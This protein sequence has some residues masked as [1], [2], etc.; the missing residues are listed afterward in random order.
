MNPKVSVIL[1]TYNRASYLYSAIKSVLNQ[2][3]KDFE[4][5]IV[6]DAS[7]DNTKQIIDKF[8]DRRIYYIRHKENKGGS[9]ARNTGIKR[10]KGEFIAFLD[11]DDLWMPN[12]LEKQLNFI[13]NNHE[14]SVVYTGA[15]VINKH[16]KITDIIT[17]SLRGNIFPKLLKKN[18]IGSCSTVLIKKECINRVGLFDE[19]LSASQ[20]FDLWIRLAK[21]YYFD[22]INEPLFFYRVHEKRIT[23]NPQKRLRAKKLLYTKH[24]EELDRLV[25]NT[26]ARKILGFWHYVLGVLYCQCGEIG[27]GKKELIMAIRNDPSSIPYYARLLFAFSGSTIFDLTT[28]I[29]NSYIPNS[30]KNNYV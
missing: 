5:I 21:H 23:T 22:Y 24:S 11:D 9:A 15:W 16:G 18:Y 2:T 8:D 6:D 20:D 1:P 30:I 19:N 3:F 12:K 26:Q 25:D 27:Q 14:I 17:P 13:N 4:I 29:L 10:S 7:T 28:T